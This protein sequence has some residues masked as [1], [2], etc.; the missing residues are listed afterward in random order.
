MREE[1][2]SSPAPQTVGARD[3]TS[4]GSAD[5]I[6]SGIEWFG[7]IAIFGA[8]VLRAA[9]RRP[10]ELREVVRQLDE[11][12]SKSAGL[13]ALAGA[14][15]GVVISLETRDSLVRFGAKAALPSLV[16]LS[17]IR[18][19]GP[20]ITAL[21]MSGRVGA[22]IGAE[23]GAMKVTEQI[24]AME[25][26][27]VDP[28][29]YLAAT[30]VMACMIMLP[31]LTL[32]C[33]CAGILMGWIANTLVEPISLTRFLNAG[34]QR[35]TFH[36]FLPPTLK[37][38]LFGFIIGIVASFQG[39]RATGGTQGVGAAATSSVVLASLFVIIADVFMVR[40]IL[41]LFPS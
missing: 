31:L 33:D 3:T 25:V 20:I 7:A 2:V 13:V 12:G 36:D 29:K 4:G 37:T 21:V 16:I 17:I 38:V 1:L 40:L 41:V 26:S 9:V 8:R 27:A 22:G 5:A 15:I 32:V 39:M 28:H 35:V 24:D 18:I 34:L 14:A 19:T 30:R 11:I 23:L 10:F 6:W